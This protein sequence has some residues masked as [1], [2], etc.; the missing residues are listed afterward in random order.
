M[1]H[2][3]HLLTDTIVVSRFQGRS[4]DAFRTPVYGP[5]E[6]VR[7]AVSEAFVKIRDSDG[8]E[9]VSSTQIVTEGRIAL[10]DRIW[11]AS[12]G[13]DS[14]LGDDLTDDSQARIPISI[15]NDRSRASG[16]FLFQTFL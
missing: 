6:R 11:V 12:R 16:K 9:R 15:R 4:S 10:E 7:A 3:R 8:N 14:G 13:G 5:Q 1:T 2:F